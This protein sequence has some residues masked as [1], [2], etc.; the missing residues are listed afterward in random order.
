MV[1]SFQAGGFTVAA[2]CEYLYLDNSSGN[3]YES[4]SGY[5]LFLRIARGQ[6]VILCHQ[7]VFLIE[8]G[9]DRLNE[10]IEELNTLDLNWGLFGNSGG[11]WACGSAI[12]I[13]DPF[14]DNQCVGGPFPRKCHSLDENFIVARA[15]ANLALS[16]DLK[17]FHLY[18]TELCLVAAAL[19]HQSYVVDFYLYHAG[20]AKMDPT[21][22]LIRSAMIK[23]YSR[24]SAMRMVRSPCSEMVFAPWAP[25]AWLANTTLGLIISRLLN[26][27][28]SSPPTPNRKITLKVR[29]LRSASTPR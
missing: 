21:Y 16:G 10:V 20:K 13:R 6:Y 23:K 19:G 9:L 8:D 24:G 1:K 17:G 14:G 22:E 26:R 28:F 7:D 3:K 12:R 4:Y 18:G 15:D 27:V 11:I 25:F 29:Q 5:N 2:G